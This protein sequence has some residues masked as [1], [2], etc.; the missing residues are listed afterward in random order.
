MSATKSK[1]IHVV[2]SDGGWRV[3][4]P[5]ANKA[6]AVRSTKTSAVEKAKSI[7]RNDHA[8]VF[9]H[10]NDGKITSVE[11]FSNRTKPSKSSHLRTSQVR[12]YSRSSSS[13]ST[14]HK[15]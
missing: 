10:R 4:R 8:S 11:N 2:P 5:D 15:K 9:I 14:N 12:G 6:S 13:K 1:N 7:A 3:V